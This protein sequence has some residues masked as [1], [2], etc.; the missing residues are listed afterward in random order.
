VLQAV[1]GTELV[2]EVLLFAADPTTAERS[3]PVD[4]IELEP[5]ALVFGYEHRVLVEE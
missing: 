1:K 3:K 2:E 5:H 4:R